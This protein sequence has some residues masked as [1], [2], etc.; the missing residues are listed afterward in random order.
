MSGED[1]HFCSDFPRVAAVRATALSGVF[2]FAVLTD[3][4]PVQ[5]SCLTVAQGRLGATHN[6]CGTDVGVLLEW[7]ADGEAQTPERNVIRNIYNL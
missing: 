4:Y 7:L 1:G 3:N 2:A 5:I 6:T